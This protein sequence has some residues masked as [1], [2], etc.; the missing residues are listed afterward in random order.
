[1]PTETQQDFLIYF[2]CRICL[3][4]V[5]IHSSDFVSISTQPYSAKIDCPCGGS[6]EHLGRVTQENKHGHDA[7]KSVCDDR[8]TSA[9]GPSCNC[10]CGGPNH[11]TGRVVQV[12]VVDGKATI[13]H[14]DP[15]T[16]MKIA[17]EYREAVAQV[18]ASLDAKFPE[19]AGYFG[20]RGYHSL[21]YRN[22]SWKANRDLNKFMG[23]KQH[24]YRMK[25]LKTLM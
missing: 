3:T 7:V 1:M 24:S 8:C 20:K 12:F 18:I 5:T 19:D 4:A 6:L 13:K 10:Q 9:I 23:F 11:G 17:N 21:N 15:D 22:G 25:M 14:F 2:R 16:S